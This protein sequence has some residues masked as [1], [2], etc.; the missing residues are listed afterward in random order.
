MLKEL[1]V[2]KIVL[3]NRNDLYQFIFAYQYFLL[4][5]DLIHL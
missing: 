3:T 2:V 4:F 1:K 5:L